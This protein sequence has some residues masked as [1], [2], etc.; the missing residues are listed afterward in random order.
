[1]ARTSHYSKIKIFG[2]NSVVK[3]I[4]THCDNVSGGLPG[5]CGIIC[6]RKL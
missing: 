2:G 1:M 6:L 4:P 5:E 3:L